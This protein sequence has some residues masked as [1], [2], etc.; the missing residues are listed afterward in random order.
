MVLFRTWKRPPSIE[1]LLVTLI[2]TAHVLGLTMLV[3]IVLPN[4]KVVEAV[5]LMHCVCLVPGVLNVFSRNMES[6]KRYWLLAADI[7]AILS[8]LSGLFVWAGLQWGKGRYE[9]IWVLPVSLF[10][11]SFGWWENYVD[12]S[13]SFGKASC[14]I[15]SL[16]SNALS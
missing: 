1:F 14:I 3:Y 10:L 2:E 9:L 16:R 13:S 11:V 15:S 5:M 8:Q 6:D 7:F 12:K 4:L